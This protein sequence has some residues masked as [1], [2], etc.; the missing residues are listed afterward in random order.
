MTT[1]IMYEVTI[2]RKLKRS[3]F[4]PNLSFTVMTNLFQTKPTNT[5]ETSNQQTPAQLYWLR[6]ASKLTIR[7]DMFEVKQLQLT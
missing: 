7:L 3:T 2:Q 5:I 1:L 6:I 4:V